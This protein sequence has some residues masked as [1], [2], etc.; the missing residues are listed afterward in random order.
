MPVQLKQ[1]VIN[2][3]RYLVRTC[4]QAQRI[5]ERVANQELPEQP[6][7]GI[8]PRDP[9]GMVVVKKPRG[10]LAIR[11]CRGFRLPRHKPSLRIAVAFR[12]HLRSVQMHH[13]THLGNILFCA[14]H[15]MV[16]GQQ[17]LYGKVVYPLHG[18]GF[19]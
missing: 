3:Q 15:R 14:V 9:H 2:A 10:V 6:G 4:G 12:R 8:E 17:V 7:H 19:A 13:G 1:P 16:D 11:V 18:N 5:F